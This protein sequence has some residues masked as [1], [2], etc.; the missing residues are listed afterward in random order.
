LGFTFNFDST[1][2]FN[3]TPIVDINYFVQMIHIIRVIF[4][5]YLAWYKEMELNFTLVF[6][7]KSFKG[8]VL[9][10]SL[11]LISFI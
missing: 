10:I 5:I 2:E 8:I 1:T 11:K 9:Y 7:I 3:L 6:D 4:I